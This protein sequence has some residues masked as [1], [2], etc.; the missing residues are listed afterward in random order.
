MSMVASNNLE[1]CNSVMMRW[2]TLDLTLFISLSW[3]GESE[4]NAVSEADAA[5]DITSI[6]RIITIPNKKPAYE[7]MPDVETADRIKAF[8]ASGSGSATVRTD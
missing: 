5:A 8:I 4:K 7:A 1:F 3:A 6:I 2:F